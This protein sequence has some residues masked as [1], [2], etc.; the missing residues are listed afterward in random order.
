M[1]TLRPKDSKYGVK[2]IDLCDLGVFVPHF[3]HGC[4]LGA[5]LGGAACTDELAKVDNRISV[6]D[7]VVV[8]KS[9]S[10]STIGYP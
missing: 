9:C 3:T 4:R 2:T 5:Q 6:N 1:N 10:K 8:R 7:S